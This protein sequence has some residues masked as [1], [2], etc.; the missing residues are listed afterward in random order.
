VYG[1]QTPETVLDDRLATR[2]DYDAIFGTVLNRF[3]VQ[4]VLG[5]SLTIYG[6]GGQTRGVIDIRDTVE[7]LRITS[8]QPAARGEFRVFNQMTESFTITEL[9]K[10]VATAYSGEVGIENLDNPRVESE[11]H[12]YNVVHSGLVELGL[13]PHRLSE[14]LISSMF[15]VA[16]RYKHRVDRDALLPLVNWRRTANRVRPS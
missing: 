1:Q 7:C 15:D 9:A 16:E 10:V 11:M 13:T 3:V 4:A 8:E 5:E 2:F 12:Y 14:T 6:E